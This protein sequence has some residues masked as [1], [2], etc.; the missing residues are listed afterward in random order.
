MFIKLIWVVKYLDF[1]QKYITQKYAISFNRVI[2]E[3]ILPPINLKNFF[4]TSLP[5]LLPPNQKRRLI[6]VKVEQC[7]SE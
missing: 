3:S 4:K 7:G 1:T 5:T 6:T 2:I